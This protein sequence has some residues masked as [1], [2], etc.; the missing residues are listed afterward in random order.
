METM[1]GVTVNTK[2]NLAAR[3]G[4]WSTQNRKK[5]IFGWLAFVLIAF[6]IGSMMGSKE[7]D[8]SE[9]GV[10]ESGRAAEIQSAA[11]PEDENLAEEHVLFQSTNQ[12][13][14]RPEYRAAVADVA[15]R[16]EHTEYVQNVETPY[17]AGANALSS[18][19]RSAIITYEIRGDSEQIPD[20]IDGPVAAIEDEAKGHPALR[21]EP[22]GD[23]SIAQ[24]VTESEA[25]DF[26]KAEFTSLPLTLLILVLAFGA[27]VAA[28]IPMLLAITGVLAT[29]GLT[30]IVSHIQ[31]VAGGVDSLILLVGLAVGVDYALFYLRRAREYRAAGYENDA[32]IEAAAASSGRAVLISGLTVAVSMAGMYLAGIPM[33]ISFATATIIVVLVSVLGAMT[34]LPAVLSKLGDRVEKGRVPFHGRLKRRTAE[35]GIWSRIT[36]RVLRRPALAVALASGLLIALALPTLGMHTALSGTESMSRDIDVV[37]TWDRVQEAFPE[38]SIPVIAVV[39]ADDVTTTPIKNAIAELESKAAARTDLYEG[40]ATVE[41]SDNREVA[42]IMIPAAGNGTDE[43]STR[44]LNEMR[45]NIIPRTVGRE[46]GVETAITGETAAIEDFN[47]SLSSH[48]PYV[49]AFVLTMAFLL[50]LVTFRSIVI[51]LKAIVLNLLSVGAAYGIL[52]MVFQ[53]GWGESLLGFES[54]GAVTAWLPPFLFVILFGLSMDYHVFIL[55]RIREAYDKGMTTDDAISHGIKSTAGVVT[56]AAIVMVGVFALFGTMQSVDMKQMG[57]GLAAAV[58]IDATIIRGILLPASM[59]LLGERNWW[60]PKRLGWIPELKVEG[61]VAPARA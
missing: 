2:G 28:G 38:E 37:Q 31:P 5:A 58:L 48:L 60:L 19:G 54:N 22:Y 27:L 44:A 39:K 35:I 61:E 46:R 47:A 42:T 16:L 14:S 53:K 11:F 4:R 43:E 49:F 1:Q 24:A 25:E 45:D 33:F 40:S 18:D 3:A 21:I 10:G 30:Q 52:V 36:D 15:E 32:A 8:Q 29:M 13:A 55:S 41:I 51:P 17:E 7:M 26:Q 57:I 50:L 34:V 59:K 23:A 12:A 56:S 9:Q 20:R 6:Q